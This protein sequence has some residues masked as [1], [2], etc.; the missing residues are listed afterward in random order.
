M[1]ATILSRMFVP[2]EGGTKT[3]EN[4]TVEGKLESELARLEL[5]HDY[6]PQKVS[7]GSYV[8]FARRGE[9]IMNINL[10]N[11]IIPQALLGGQIII[12]IGRLIEVNQ[13]RD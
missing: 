2:R 4:V 6:Q 5:I 13:A 11:G 3:Q 12:D 7:R 10:N 1:D 9:I 8:S